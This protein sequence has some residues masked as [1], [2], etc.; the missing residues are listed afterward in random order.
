MTTSAIKNPH[1]LA[2][3]GGLALTAALAGIALPA[4]SATIEE[5]K[6][7][8]YM[9]V[10]TEDD[11]VPFEFV[12]DGKQTGFDNEVLALVK[13]KIGFDVRQ[14]VMP[15]AGILPG[16]TTGKYDMAMTA[17]LITEER[18]QTFDF[19][20]PTCASINYF[21]TKVGSPITKPDDLLGKTVGAETGSAMLS[22]L[23][24][25]DEELKAR[26][27]GKGIGKIVEYQGYP[28]A[29]Q[30]VALGR[31]DAVIN[32]QISLNS[33]LKTK[34]G[35]FALG[36]PIGKPTYIAWAIK[37]GNT[38]LLKTVDAAL[39][40]L[41]ASGELYKLQE[42]WLGASFKEMPASAN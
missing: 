21:A 26:N 42:K 34:P 13:K 31:L 24:T 11:Y 15:W 14:Q 28:E 6:A 25:F 16:V 41:R 18:K 38:G 32:T 1:V 30:D 2:R 8:G 5:I 4:A 7:R 33:L 19:S 29:Y 20:S 17:V 35:V 37:K 12:V 23:K 22:T 39:L 9:S 3:L 36:A 27:G 10:A 40:D